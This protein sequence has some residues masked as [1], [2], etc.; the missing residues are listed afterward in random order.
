M[1]MDHRSK[2]EAE[3]EDWRPALEM[4]PQL[5]AERRG[6]IFRLARKRAAYFADVGDL[7]AQASIDELP[8]RRESIFAQAF[9]LALIVTRKLSVEEQ[10]TL[11]TP[12][13]EQSTLVAVISSSSR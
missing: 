4:S 12:I 9:Q 2:P 5:E 13:A 1:S 10:P 8:T 3:D 11:E 7:S 6:M